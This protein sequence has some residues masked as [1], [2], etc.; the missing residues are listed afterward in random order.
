MGAKDAAKN[1]IAS[2]AKKS[3]RLKEEG[4]VHFVAKNWKEALNSYQKALEMTMAGTEERASLYSNRAACFLMENRYREAIRESDAALESKPDFKPALVRRSRAYEQINEYSKA[5]SDLESA[6]KVDPADEGLKKKL[7]AMKSRAANQ[8]AS[9]RGAGAGVAGLG[10]SSLRSG[11]LNRK[12]TRLTPQQQQTAAAAAAAANQP[13]RPGQQQQQQMPLLTLNCKLGEVKKTVVLPISV[14]YRD[15][16]EAVKNTFSSSCK[17]PLALKYADPEGELMTVT[18]RADLRN[19]LASAV[20]AHEKRAA[21]TGAPG[22]PQG[23]LPPVEIECV[24]VA[25]AVTETPEVVTPQNVGAAGTTPED[26]EEPGEDVIEIDEWLLTFASLFRRHLGEAGEKEGPL[27]LRAVGLEK[28]CEALEAAVGTDEAKDLLAAAADKFQE[29]AAA[30]ILNKGNVHVCAARKLVGGDP[31]GGGSQVVEE[32]TKLAIKN[33]MKRLDQEYD[34]AVARYVESLAIKPDFY[35]TTI[36]WGQQAFERG[37]HYHVASKDATGAAAA[38]RAK[39]CDEMFELAEKKFQESLDMLPAEDKD[40]AAAAETSTSGG[41]E[42]GE[43]KANEL[44]VK[45]QILVLWGNVLFERSQV[46]RGREDGKWEDDTHAAVKKF[47]DAGCSKTDITRALMNH[48]SKKWAN[49]KD[50]IAAAK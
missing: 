47:N 11:A 7:N 30:A 33:H 46:R 35:E 2:F 23:T 16:A 25:S 31:D 39:E 43:E 34:D 8:K 49:E 18:S 42:G 45:S 13:G 15:I 10:G 32:A 3:D 41:E 9:R 40:A 21:A 37:K 48:T 50:A 17:E 24:I 14:R 38:E 20:S 36:A 27:D 6:L 4:N 19:A 29:A 12:N 1:E 22:L 26:E 28:C 44:S 5:V